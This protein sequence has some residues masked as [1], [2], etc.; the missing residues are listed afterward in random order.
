MT[1]SVFLKTAAVFLLMF[2]GACGTAHQQTEHAHS[3]YK[4]EEN[5]SVKSLSDREVD[6]YLNGRGMGFAKVAELN[7][8]PGPMHVLEL[9]QKLDLTAEQKAAVQN[10]FQK[11]KDKAVGLG[12]K[13]VEKEKELNQ[14]FA[15]GRIDAAQLE[16]KT[17][18]IADLQG[19]LRR[20]HL[21]AHLETKQILSA[22]QV[23][24]YNQLRGY[25]K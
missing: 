21:Y 11:M 6:D 23:E 7:S 9:E 14:M 16:S 22:A 20:A 13:I 2:A 15:D 19:D 17:A 18:E 12:N 4:G 24:S 5:R 3:P 1:T 10:S 25:Q 8:F